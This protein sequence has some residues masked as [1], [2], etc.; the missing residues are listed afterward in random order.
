[1]GAGKKFKGLLPAKNRRA[2]G[3]GNNNVTVGNGNNVVVAG[4][5]GDCSTAPCRR[6][7]GQ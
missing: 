6:L 4:T 7:R 2:T 3:D 5:G 1:M